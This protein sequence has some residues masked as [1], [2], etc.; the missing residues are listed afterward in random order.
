[1]EKYLFAVAACA[2]A[3][4]APHAGAQAHRPTPPA[5]TCGSLVSPRIGHQGGMALA[6]E[7]AE[8]LAEA[9]AACEQ[10]VKDQP[11]DAW[12]YANL[13]RVRALSGDAGG[14]L[15][16]ARKGAEMR[17]HIAQVLLGVML[18]ESGDYAAAR[19]QL[20]NAARWGSPYADFNLGVM[21]ANGW[22]SERDEADA[23]AAFLKA[24]N[25]GDPLAM[26]VLAQRY[27][28]PRAG[29]WLQKAAEA[30]NPELPREP[31]RISNFQIDNAALLAWYRDKARTEP[32]AQAYMGML[33]ESGQW[34]RQDH[35]AAASWYRRAGEAGNVPA[36]WRL[37]RFYNEGRG[38]PKDVAEARRWGQMHEVKRCEQ[39][40]LAEAGANACDRLA[41]D[42]YDPGRVVAG[43][44][45]FCMRH[46]AERAVAACTAAVKR[47]PST[48]RYRTQLARSLAHTGRFA[49]ARR[50]AGAAAAKGSTTSMILLGVMS[51]RGLGS[52]KDESD[53]LAWYRK[54]ADAG[55]ARA[56]SLVATAAYNGVGVAKDSLEAKA[57]LE[58]LRAR[59]AV[60]PPVAGPTAESGDPRAQH[61]L[62]AQLEREKKYGEALKWYERAAA[63]G[64]RP[65]EMNL[66]Q[67]YEKGIGVAQDTAEAS[68]RYRRLAE[69]GDGEARYRAARLA[70]N[71]GD[72]PEALKLYERGVR[73][74]DWR[75]ILDLGEIHEHGRGVP[76]DARRA[77]AL[78]ER[79][80]GESRWARFKVGVLYLETMKDYSKAEAW[81]RRSAADD[82]PGARNNL[83][84][85]HEKGLGMKVDYAAAREHYLAAHAR[86]N[87]QAKG[88][89]ENFFAAGLGSPSF[90]DYRAGAEAGISSAQ[91]RL[92]MM[93]A[94]GEGVAR[95]DRL[96]AEWLKKA[97][98]QGHAEARKE[99]AELFYKMGDDMEAAALGHE[100]AARR[101]ADKLAQSG[102]PGAA[103]ELR[104]Y[105]AAPRHFPAPPAWPQGVTTD[106]GEDQSRTIM[107]RIAGVAVP[108]AAAMDAAM[109]NV[110]DIIRWFPETD[111]KK[112][113][114]GWGQSPVPVPACVSRFWGSDPEFF[115]YF[116]SPWNA[117]SASTRSTT[118]SRTARW[119][120]FHP[121][122][123]PSGFRGRR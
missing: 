47:S 23:A 22:G 65:S 34:V 116:R 85:M 102:Q 45:S 2:L 93:Y 80:A 88:N 15:E 104:R 115:R 60:V 21:L 24:A 73:D 4:A 33:Y 16:A 95:N 31:L 117:S 50:E 119:F 20:L 49:E 12:V 90:E 66:A 48:V 39:L 106:P 5:H 112:K 100:A 78:Y 110:Y 8:K 40:E 25:G 9:R 114:L 64:F 10:A 57:L 59:P 17:W 63:Q 103:E 96:A 76:K 81:L 51:Q 107:V 14:A 94:R 42:R 41:A 91:Y 118:C 44:D 87:P 58:A 38:V 123:L 70:A 19:Q 113:V 61:N 11:R 3:L 55:D 105:L 52:A 1:M 43:V 32:W 35:A 97:A 54:A 7:L 79:V 13:A 83:G 108:Q 29:H 30:M 89:L 37:A 86:G 74:G 121:C 28:K 53:A 120:R 71:A 99:A 18:A 72:T 98:G 122:N 109:G 75:S 111:G 92:G 77:L 84:W 36:Q 101:L 27:D 69:L 82:H 67:M 46:F 68:K 26:Q 62:A 56:A 6:H